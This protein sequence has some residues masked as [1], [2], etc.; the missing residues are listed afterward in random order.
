MRGDV[1]EAFVAREHPGRTTL[2]HRQRNGAGVGEQRC[3][4]ARR[5]VQHQHAVGTEIGLQALQRRCALAVGLALQLEHAPGC[6]QHRHRSDRC[7]GIQPIVPGGLQQ[8]AE[9]GGFIGFQRCAV[10]HRHR[11]SQALQVGADLPEHFQAAGST[12]LGGHRQHTQLRLG[13][14]AVQACGLVK[15]GIKHQP[16]LSR[17]GP[18]ARSRSS[19]SALPTWG[20]KRI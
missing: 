1:L 9:A 18:R 7:A 4:Q 20:R 3:Q 13:R 15:T 16:V 17:S 6:G 5:R 19:S 12:L 2:H 8:M 14:K 10:Q 11:V